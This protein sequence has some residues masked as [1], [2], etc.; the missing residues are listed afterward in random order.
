M[1][2]RQEAQIGFGTVSLYEWLLFLHV[3]AAFLLAAG[4][5]TYGVLVFN[6]GEA[7]QR[8]LA[9][10]AV[11]LWNAGG[12]GVLVF[13]IWLA[14]EVDGYEVWDGWILAAIVLWLVASA[15]GGRLARGVREG[16]ALLDAGRARLLV[17]VM[18]VAT[19]ALLIDMIF[20]PGA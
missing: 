1:A 13:G 16:T 2:I 12:L 7:V 18:A 9:P 20:K 3:L 4:V 8:A 19:V 10:P 14:L 15:A 6:G 17:A 11:A 5:T